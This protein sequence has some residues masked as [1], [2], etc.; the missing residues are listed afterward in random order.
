MAPILIKRKNAK[1]VRNT[2]G[3]YVPHTTGVSYHPFHTEVSSHDLMQ[4]KWSKPTETA[5]AIN[6]VEGRRRA[7]TSPVATGG[8]CPSGKQRPPT[9]RGACGPDRLC[10][11]RAAAGSEARWGRTRV[12]E[13]VHQQPTPRA[14]ASASA[15]VRETSS[16]PLK[17]SKTKETDQKLNY[18]GL[19]SAENAGI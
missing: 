5:K 7:L 6:K 9:R 16:L 17:S 15:R 19:S 4:R 3:R 14:A 8:A 12:G 13:P 1:N 11:H 18:K 10:A 2:C